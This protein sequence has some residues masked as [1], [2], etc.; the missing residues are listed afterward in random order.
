MTEPVCGP[1]SASGSDSHSC[2]GERWH[3]AKQPHQR[4]EV[5]TRA[6]CFLKAFGR[7]RI[8]KCMGLLIQAEEH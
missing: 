4:A 5:W 1:F 3:M 2:T 8:Q 7:T 6:G